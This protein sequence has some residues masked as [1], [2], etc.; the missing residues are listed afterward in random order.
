MIAAGHF[1]FL[2]DSKNV[3]L[4]S[5]GSGKISF[6]CDIIAVIDIAPEAHAVASSVGPLAARLLALCYRIW[7]RIEGLRIRLGSGIWNR[8]RHGLRIQPPAVAPAIDPIA[9]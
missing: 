9:E 6:I 1:Y 4:A 2:I 8:S 5:G 7:C 3:E